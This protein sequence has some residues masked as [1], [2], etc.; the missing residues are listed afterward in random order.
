MAKVAT[1]GSK[2]KCPMCDGNKPHVGGKVTSGRGRVFVCGRLAA[3]EGSACE[4]ES[5]TPNAV[6][7]GSSHVYVGG[8]PLARVGDPTEHGGRITS[9]CASVSAG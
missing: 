4:C 2:H 8:K 9:G 6:S 7:S 3:V 5:P 1:V